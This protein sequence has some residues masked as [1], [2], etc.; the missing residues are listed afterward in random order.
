LLKKLINRNSE[1]NEI[2]NAERA[3]VGEASQI[4]S[5]ISSNDLSAYY[6]TYDYGN[7]IFKFK[8]LH[9]FNYSIEKKMV[10]VNY[11]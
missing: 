9:L 6:F 7:I 3:S 4:S 8:L 5:T 11:T 2:N 1:L 10:P